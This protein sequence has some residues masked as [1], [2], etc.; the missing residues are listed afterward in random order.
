MTSEWVQRPLG[1][2][3]TL[4]RGHDL[5]SQDRE[6]GNVPIMG[7][8]GLTGFH[9]KAKTNGP[10]VVVGRSGNSMGVV[11][12]C[13]VDYWPLN[14]A[15]YVTD[16]KGNDERFIYYLLTT[17]NFD[18]FNSGSAQKSLNRNAVYPYEVVLPKTIEEQRKISQVLANLEAKYELNNE[19]NQTLEQTAQAIFKSW[20][21]DFEPVKAKIAVLDA[22][23]S[24]ED[25]LIAAMQAISGKDTLQLATMQADQ[26]EQ[27]VE[28]QATAEL[29]PSAMQQSELG[30][31]PEGWELV[32]LESVST[33][34]TKGT[35][36]KKSELSEFGQSSTVPFIKVKDISG[37][38]EILADSLE[39]IPSKVSTTS[40]KR[41]ILRKDDLL[42][43]IAGTI[44]RVAVV[45]D[46]LEN[47][48]TNQ[49][50]GIIRLKAPQDSLALIRQFLISERVQNDISSKVVQGVQANASLKN[51]KDINLLMP[52]K[53]LA[54]VAEQKLGIL[55][56]HIDINRKENKRLAAIR[57]NL[58]P[59]LLSGEVSV[60]DNHHNDPGEHPTVSEAN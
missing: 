2:V 47:S 27:Y 35:T 53:R 28:L 49:A 52:S 56:K 12:F 54:E 15:L 31:I 30:E 37:N 26:P 23:G 3:I 8:S 21:E 44:G 59:K 1:E 17:I 7:S 18:Q 40:L 38:G 60:E 14:T 29:F 48:N 20:F 46:D 57:D 34:I 4:Q 42:F 45:N 50:V 32:N 5:P 51:L 16:F 6:D 22:G 10:G 24:D 36:P 11:S 33:L 58:L 25:A 9:N 41:S 13:P 43:S 19:I 39:D 55:L